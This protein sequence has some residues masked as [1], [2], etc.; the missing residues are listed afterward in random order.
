MYENQLI[1][2]SMVTQQEVD[3]LINFD[4]LEVDDPY[5][6]EL[7]QEIIYNAELI[8]GSEFK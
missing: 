7:E 2:E 6:D 8:H 4:D 3:T 5:L 1:N